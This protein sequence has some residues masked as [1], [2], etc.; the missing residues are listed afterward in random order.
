[1]LN[2][3][4]KWEKYLNSLIV[5]INNVIENKELSAELKVELIDLCDILGNKKLPLDIR[6][7]QAV[8]VEHYLGIIDDA[9]MKKS[10]K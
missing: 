8:V 5:K 9:P 10:R 6:M 3:D 7:K 1:M 4:I 2:N